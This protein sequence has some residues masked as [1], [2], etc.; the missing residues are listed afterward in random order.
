MVFV[1]EVRIEGIPDDVSGE[2]IGAAIF[3]NEEA[4]QQEYEGIK[5]SISTLLRPQ[6]FYF[7]RKPLPKNKNGK[8]DDKKISRILAERGSKWNGK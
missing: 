2:R 8:F 6:V 3:G 1:S 5:D 4:F 7:S